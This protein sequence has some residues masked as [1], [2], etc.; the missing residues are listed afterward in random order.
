MKDNQQIY[1][2]WHIKSFKLK[3][4]NSS[5]LRGQ[6]RVGYP[7]KFIYCLQKYCMKYYKVL[8]FIHETMVNV[9]VKT[10][11]QKKIISFLPQ[12][13]MWCRWCRIVVFHVWKI[14]SAKIKSQN[15]SCSIDFLWNFHVDE[16]KTKQHEALWIQKTG[17]SHWNTTFDYDTWIFFVTPS[18]VISE[19]SRCK[20]R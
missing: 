6:S 20:C 17:L 2:T 9:R 12:H 18:L 4:N 15:I 14:L 1:K 10:K 11:M 7:L 16:E 13:A 3:K 8:V 19:V 5:S